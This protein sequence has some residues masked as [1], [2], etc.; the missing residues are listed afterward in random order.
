M[1][2]Q[3]IISKNH[4]DLICISIIFKKLNE[5]ETTIKG[6]KIKPKQ[7]FNIAKDGLKRTDGRLSARKNV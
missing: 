7:I 5:N 2:E 4:D 6:S 3:G 1:K